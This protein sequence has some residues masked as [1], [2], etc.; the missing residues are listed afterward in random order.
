LAKVQL[1]N[2]GE[3]WIQDNDVFDTWF[4][5]GQWPYATLTANDLMDTFFPS[6]VMETGYDILELWVSRMIML[7]LYHEG[8]VPFKDVYLHG[9]VKAPDGQK[10]SKSKN[11]VIAP[12]ELINKYGADS[13]RLLYL[14]G[15]KA[16]A[17]YPIS[18]EKLEGHKRFLNKIWNAS[19]FVI[20]NLEGFDPEQKFKKSD[21]V[22]RDREL[23][24]NQK[25]LAQKITRSIKA[26]R[27][28]LA[29]EELYQVFWHDFCDLYLE[30]VKPRLYSKD[31]EGNPINQAEEEQKAML[32]GKYT[33]LTALKVYLKLLHPY[34]P[35]LSERI[36]QELPC[37][38]GE[39]KTIMHAGWPV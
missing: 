21:L 26:F 17:G 27:L 12:D 33:L 34:V 23:L 3:G 15:N 28:G 37:S 9:L 20:S 2:P 35:F 1:E 7:S 31:R 8:K 32:S 18:Y 5:S 36:W 25:K 39:S 38:K 11:N 16:G 6:N 10:M 19:K 4:S 22:E 29:A 13:V 30:E 24:D 14:V